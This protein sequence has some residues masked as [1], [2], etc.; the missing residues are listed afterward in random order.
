MEE[1]LSKADVFIHNL[2]PGAVDRL[3]FSAAELKEKYPQLIICSISGY[4]TF[5]PYT[6]KKSIRPADS[7]RG[8]VGIG[9]RH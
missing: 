2:A 5:G 4:G 3:G 6:N 9:Y 7:M 8:W 1:L